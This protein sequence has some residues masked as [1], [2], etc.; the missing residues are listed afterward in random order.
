MAVA[1]FQQGEIVAG[2]RYADQALRNMPRTNGQFQEVVVLVALGHLMLGHVNRLIHHVDTCLQMLPDQHLLVLLRGIGYLRRRYALAAQDL[3]R[4]VTLFQSSA[5]VPKVVQYY[6]TIAAAEIRVLVQALEMGFDS[7]YFEAGQR[8]H[9]LRE[10]L[11]HLVPVVVSDCF[12]STAIKERPITSKAA[13]DVRLY[14][15][16]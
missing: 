1:Q 15:K 11:A 3:S 16:V 5:G 4:A 13:S 14:F 7:R 2:L 9:Q 8:L 12:E 10:N 6:L